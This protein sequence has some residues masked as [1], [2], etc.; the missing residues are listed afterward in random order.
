MPGVGGFAARAEPAASIRIATIALAFIYVFT[1]LFYI[2]RA[3]SATISYTGRLAVGAKRFLGFATPVNAAG[4]FIFR[5]AMTLI[6]H[7]LVAQ[8]AASH[9]KFAGIFGGG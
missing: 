6:I 2:T 3:S 7:F 9:F 1:D 8:M 5:L 4:E